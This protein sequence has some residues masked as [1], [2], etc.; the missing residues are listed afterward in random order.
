MSKYRVEVPISVTIPVRSDATHIGLA[1]SNAISG[2]RAT[3]PMGSTDLVVYH[4]K[5]KVT[6]LPDGSP[7]CGEMWVKG[8]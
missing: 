6:E 4:D 8:Q 2:I 1:I 3:L 7:M 5:I